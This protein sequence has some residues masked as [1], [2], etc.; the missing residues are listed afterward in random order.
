MTHTHVPDA[1]LAELRAEVERLRAADL[2]AAAHRHC[3]VAIAESPAPEATTAEGIYWLTEKLA[4]AEAALRAVEALRSA[5]G[6]RC[7][8]CTGHSPHW[9]GHDKN[10]PCEAGAWELLDA[11][12]ASHP[13]GTPE[14]DRQC[15]HEAVRA[16][17]PDPCGCSCGRRPCSTGTPDPTPNTG[18]AEDWQGLLSMRWTG[19][20]TYPFVED[21]NANITGYGHQDK[22]AFAAAVNAYDED[23]NGGP[24]PE[25]DQ[26][27][28]DSIAHQWVR[29]DDDGERLRPVAEG[30][31]DAIPV[32]TLWGQR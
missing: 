23:C 27:T 20:T 16:T 32:T 10:P 11:V 24:I 4:A 31:P 5:R 29:P 6:R 25:E 21:E 14:V 13:T 19:D 2:D 8:V 22:G 7:N 18:E 30:T 1:E 28:A 26:W 3:L 9:D 15:P 17:C 12:L